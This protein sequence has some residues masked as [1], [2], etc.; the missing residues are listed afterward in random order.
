MKKI[1]IGIIVS[2]VCAIS[3]V[4]LLYHPELIKKYDNY[5]FLFEINPT[6]N[7]L[8]FVIG[9]LCLPLLYIGY[10][11][12]KEIS[13]E[14][15]KQAL[16]RSDWV[17]LF[18]IALGCVVHS[19]YHFIPLFH[20]ENKHL[21]ILEVNQIKMVELLFVT[22]YIIFC[23]I[24]TLQSLK[25]KNVLLYSNRYFN[26]LF[27]MVFVIIITVITPKYG[28]YLAVSAFN[29]SIGFYFVGILINKRKAHL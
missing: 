6:S 11:G 7:T 15:S 29:L 27:W 9:M 17:V 25:V 21:F 8:G 10:K 28:G 1:Y 23:T 20:L 4:L 26:P 24:I 16:D 18:V 22:F 5:Q 12:V 3:D 2:I 13:D 14:Y 19:L